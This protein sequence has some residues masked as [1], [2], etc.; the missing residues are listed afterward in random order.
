[1]MQCHQEIKLTISWWAKTHTHRH[2]QFNAVGLILGGLWFCAVEPGEELFSP[3]PLISGNTW[4]YSYDLNN[5][6]K[7][8]GDPSNFFNTYCTWLC[9]FGLLYCVF[10]SFVGNAYCSMHWRT[11]HSKLHMKATGRQMYTWDPLTLNA[12]GKHSTKANFE[13]LC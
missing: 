12:E 9:P 6:Q 10:H 8:C 5:T 1:M 2:T 4:R 3:L 11:E 13:D 7:H